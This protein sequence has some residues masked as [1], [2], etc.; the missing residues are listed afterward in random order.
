MARSRIA[1]S[2]FIL[3][4]ALRQALRRFLGFSR[5]AARGAGITPQQ[6]Q[7][8]LAVKGFAGRDYISVGELARSLQLRHN[9]AVGLADRLV[10]HGLLRRTRSR[11]DARRAELRLTSRGEAAIERLATAHLRELRQ[12]GPE[13]LRLISSITGG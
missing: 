12:L 1:K 5:E 4:A 11:T 7:A 9:S 6:H 10:R 3:L 13:L 2:D 8:L